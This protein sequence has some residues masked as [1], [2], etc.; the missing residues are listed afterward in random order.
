MNY[1]YVILV[2]IFIFSSLGYVKPKTKL[3]ISASL[4]IALAVSKVSKPREF[5]GEFLDSSQSQSQ[6]SLMINSK[7]DEENDTNKLDEENDKPINELNDSVR[8][9][10]DSPPMKKNKTIKSKDNH[11]YFN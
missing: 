9:N 2:L 1:F 7:I 3:L 5:A 6:T 11:F 10:E 4:G 8:S